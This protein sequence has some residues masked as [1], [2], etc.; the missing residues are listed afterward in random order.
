MCLTYLKIAEGILSLS[1]VFHFLFEFEDD[2]NVVITGK[3]VQLLK[4][5]KPGCSIHG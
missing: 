1:R 4:I 5:T 2:R 3:T